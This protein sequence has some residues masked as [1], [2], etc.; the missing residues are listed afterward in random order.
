VKLDTGNWLLRNISVQRLVTLVQPNLF[1]F[2]MRPK[3]VAISMANV[4]AAA[5][6]III[7]IVYSL[8]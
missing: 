4:M 6:M 1:G 3:A 7:M 8:P 2:L 5:S